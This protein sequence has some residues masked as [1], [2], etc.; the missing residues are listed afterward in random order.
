MRAAL[1]LVLAA[2]ACAQP[3]RDPVEV[4]T[5]ARDKSC[6][7]ILGAKKKGDY[8]LW[9]EAT[10]RLRLDVKVSEGHEI[11]AWAGARSFDSRDIVEFVVGGPPAAFSGGLWIDPESFE[12]R[13]LTAASSELNASESPRETFCCPAGASFTSSCETALK[14]PA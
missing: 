5:H 7:Q 9:L 13:R 10:D 6:D 11:G 14:R 12:L 3:R 8:K 1:I 4:L 2:A